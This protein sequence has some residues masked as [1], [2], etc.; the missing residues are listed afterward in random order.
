MIHEKPEAKKSRASV[1]LITTNTCRNLRFR[2]PQQQ[3]IRRVGNP[4]DTMFRDRWNRDT[5]LCHFIVRAGKELCP[6]KQLSN[7]LATDFVEKETFKNK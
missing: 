5:S 3:Q 6:R 4:P 2:R 1:P 7:N